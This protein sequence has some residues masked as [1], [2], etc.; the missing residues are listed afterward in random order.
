M[1][2]QMRYDI[3]AENKTEVIK[4]AFRTSDSFS[5]LCRCNAPY[6]EGYKIAIEPLAEQLRQYL[7][8]QHEPGGAFYRYIPSKRI[9]NIYKCCR[10]TRDIMLYT[11][12]LFIKTD[13][14]VVEPEDIKFFRNGKLWLDSIY[15]EE[16]CGLDNDAASDDDL[17]FFKDIGAV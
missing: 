14:D 11:K 1:Q 16:D 7:I 9:M 6:K 8:E 2:R 10:S 15:H 3:I 5:L 13:C 12:N 17:K 4:Y